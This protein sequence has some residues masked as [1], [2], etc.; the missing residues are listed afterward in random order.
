MEH[1]CEHIQ[2]IDKPIVSLTDVEFLPLARNWYA[3]MASFGHG[4]R[5][6]I[7]TLDEQS[8]HQLKHDGVY[9][10]PLD[11]PVV[12]TPHWNQE[13]IF[14]KTSIWK[15][16]NTDCNKPFF[17]FDTDI[18]FFKDPI[19]YLEKSGKNKKF[20]ISSDRYYFPRYDM[21]WPDVRQYHK[22][23][24]TTNYEGIDGT[25]NGGVLYV[26]GPDKDNNHFILDAYETA[27]KIYTSGYPDVV[28]AELPMGYEDNDYYSCQMHMNHLIQEYQP[29][30]TY[31]RLPG[32]LF[33]N[34]SAWDNLYLRE[35]I[36][37]HGYA[38]HFNYE[39]DT[40]EKKINVMKDNN[41]WMI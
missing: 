19:P 10:V 13:E 12:E 5:I 4:D 31:K 11:V 2:A 33:A 9:T 7:F 6:I 8:E 36:M 39:Y 38:I 29:A 21:N 34:G 23:D 26:T 40:S 20:V 18:Y 22:K 17:F 1:L 27:K 32:L 24:G 14:Y 30:L 41:F 16:I 28:P 37:S 35:K 25:L 3:N 15:L